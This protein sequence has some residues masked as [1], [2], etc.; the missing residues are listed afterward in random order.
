MENVKI[1]SPRKFY[2]E[3][4]LWRMDGKGLSPKKGF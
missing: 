2:S 4:K 3:R 1:S